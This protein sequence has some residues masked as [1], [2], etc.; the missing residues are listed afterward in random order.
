M[1]KAERIR[2]YLVAAGATRIKQTSEGWAST[3]PFHSA[4]HK[5]KGLTLATNVQKACF[6]CYSGTCGRG[7]SIATILS[8]LL[9]MPW[10]KAKETAE[11]LASPPLADM[12]SLGALPPWE[13]RRE[14]GGEDP[15]EAVD[16]AIL[17][18]F[19]RCPTYMIERGF[20]RQVLKEWDIGYD[21]DNRRVTIPVWLPDGR[22]VG[23]SKRRAYETRDPEDPAYVHLGFRK[24]ALLYGEHRVDAV[25]EEFPVVVSESSMAV[26]WMAQHGRRNGVSTLSA[27]VSNEQIRLLAKYPWVTLAFDNPVTDEAGRRATIKVG[28]GLAGRVPKGQLKVI[29]E[30]PP[31]TKDLQEVGDPA[32]FISGAIPWER[33]RR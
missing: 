11:R 9:H 8:E 5:S 6:V 28:A 3:C 13:K 4:H 10:S 16:P 23:F 15:F 32:A 29:A 22:L 7:G 26:L 25:T 12:A 19:N 33:W 14:R 24:S 1:D 18:A 20:T 31:G 21:P 30:W 2:E 27:Q 17:G